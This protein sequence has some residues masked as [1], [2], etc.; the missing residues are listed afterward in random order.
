MV[1][2]SQDNLATCKLDYI[3][4]KKKNL[5]DSEFYFF[6]RVSRIK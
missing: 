4:N 6:V 2:I 1:V 5:I 3:E